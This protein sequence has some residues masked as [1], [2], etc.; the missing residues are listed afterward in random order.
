MSVPWLQVKW[1]GG[2]TNSFS[3]REHGNALPRTSVELPHG[4]AFIARTVPA[5]NLGKTPK[6]FKRIV[7]NTSFRISMVNWKSWGIH[8]HR[9]LKRILKFPRRREVNVIRLEYL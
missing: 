9:T 7:A 3:I 6:F 4:I 1:L 2:G 5:T 8:D